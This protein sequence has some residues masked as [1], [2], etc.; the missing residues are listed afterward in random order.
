MNGFK[1]R[2]LQM[3]GMSQHLTLNQLDAILD[4]GFR[5]VGI[6]KNGGQRLR[7]G[8]SRHRYIHFAPAVPADS[9]VLELGMQ[10]IPKSKTCVQALGAAAVGMAIGA[11]A[12]GALAIGAMAI[13]R[14]GI[15]S[16]RIDKLSIGEL[17]VDKLTIREQASEAYN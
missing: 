17:T 5:R 8:R 1:V 7:R 13:G 10:L 12:I 11:T 9:R 4:R 2:L 15:K 3:R 16:G 6:E 14:L